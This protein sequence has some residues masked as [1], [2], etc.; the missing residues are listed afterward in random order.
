MA[1]MIRRSYFG[2]VAVLPV[3]ALLFVMATS[4]GAAAGDTTHVS[5][6]FEPDISDDGRYV[7]FT[8][9]ATNLVEGDTNNAPDIFVRDLKPDPGQTKTIWRVSEDDSG[10]EA[11]GGSGSPSISADGRYVAF[12]SDAT[13]LV[14]GDGNGVSDV[15]VHDRQAGI[16]E[17]VS[18]DSSGAQANGES[19]WATDVS[20]NGRVAFASMASNLVPGDTNNFWDFFVHD[21]ATHK[22]ERVNVDESGNQVNGG[23]TL[24]ISISSNGRYVG[25]NTSAPYLVPDDSDNDY[26]AFV[27]DLDPELG[28]TKTIW[29]V[30]FD[31][32]QPLGHDSRAYGAPSISSDGRVAYT[33]YATNLVANDTNGVRDVFVSDLQMETTERVS[34]DSSGTQANGHSYHASSISSDGGYVTF[35]SDATNLVA[36]DTN[37]FRD[38]FVHDLATHRTERVSVDSSGTQANA[39]SFSPSISSEGRYVAFDSSATNLVAGDTNGVR[40]VFVHERGMGTTQ[41]TDSSAPT[42]THTASPLPNASGWNNTNVTVTLNAQDD[43]GGS[44]VKEIH[45]SA[46]GAQ[47]IASTVVPG[48][49]ATVN[50]STEGTTTISYFATDNAGNQESPAKTLTVNIDKS[51]PETA[52]SAGPSGYVRSTSASFSFSS[53]EA[54]STFQCSR[55]GASFTACTSPKSYSSLSQGN[56]TFRVRATDPPGNTDASPA[57]RSWFVDT[58]VPKGT[59]SINGGAY[60]TSS[61]YVT[62]TISASD[63]SP[64][65]GVVYMRFRNGGTTT[66]SSWVAY[67]TSKS[68]TLTSGAG[69]KTVYVQYRDRAGNVSASA[70]DTIRYSP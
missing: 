53:S 34:V 61:R 38:V 63:P 44:G 15:F 4:S 67:S 60:S 33:S 35:M 46:T 19:Y 23:V 1:R 21:L 17:R 59:I 64:G 49:S 14:A 22:T 36:G 12:T 31:G 39:G 57:S 20:S 37:G 27:R 24:D 54:G 29:R 7:V 28:Q 13:N 50:I 69:T 26:D 11:S 10:T 43:E 65:S 8:S 41:P 58:V 55:D 9:A 48:G 25:F 5:A 16:T 51:S 68:W 3:I 45:Y 56:H 70:Y 18:V 6:G 47:V 66:W 52:I 42:T 30:G 40:D 32:T 2:L 62:L